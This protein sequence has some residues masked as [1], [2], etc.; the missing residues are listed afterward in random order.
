MPS[1]QKELRNIWLAFYHN[2]RNS[3]NLTAG[4]IELC[5]HFSIL[6]KGCSYM[7][8]N[9]TLFVTLFF[10]NSALLVSP[11]FLLFSL[12]H[13]SPSTLSFGIK[14]PQERESD[15]TYYSLSF[16]RALPLN[17]LVSNDSLNCSLKLSHHYCS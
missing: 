13:P 9:V 8:D 5:I 14:I 11:A 16:V 7:S 15:E 1:T 12:S 10:S 6:L 17:I 2:N 3:R 4:F